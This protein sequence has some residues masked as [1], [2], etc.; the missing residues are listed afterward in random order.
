MKK[1][2]VFQWTLLTANKMIFNYM[3]KCI[4]FWMQSYM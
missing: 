3:E 1:G 4:S 2:T